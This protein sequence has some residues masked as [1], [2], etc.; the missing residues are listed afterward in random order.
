MRIPQVVLSIC[1]GVVASLIT[2]AYSYGK[3]STTVEQ[4]TQV[5]QTHTREIKELEAMFVNFMRIQ[6]VDRA[7]IKGNL[8]VLLERDS[9]VK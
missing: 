7:E 9:R 3:V 2:S 4:N 8:K 5:I 1:L 6:E